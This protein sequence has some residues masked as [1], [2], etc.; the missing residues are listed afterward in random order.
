MKKTGPAPHRRILDILRAAPAAEVQNRLL[1]IPDTD[2]AL[3][4]IY[5][6]EDERAL[7]TRLTGPAKGARVRDV[8]SRL[9]H[10]RI[11]YDQYERTAQLV[12][13]A[14]MGS[15]TGS[16]SGDGPSGTG[17]T[18]GRGSYYR[19][20]RGSSDPDPGPGRYW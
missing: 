17:P 18:G 9:E 16:R 8:L 1:R 15:G 20:S 14:L 3:S 10:T 7:V 6:A 4:M 19:P 13:D 11:R 2:L 12:V 5:M